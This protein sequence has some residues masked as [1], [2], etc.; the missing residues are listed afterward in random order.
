[1]EFNFH[2]VGV[3]TENM[4]RS[5]ADYKVI[6]GE[7]KI[8]KQHY[9]ASQGVNVC[10]V[11]VGGGV[12]IELIE[13]ADEKTTIANFIQKKIKYYHAGYTVFDFDR[14]IEHLCRNNF[15]HLETFHSEA[16]GGN[17]CAFLYTNDL[18]LI[19]LIEKK[20]G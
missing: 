12:F 9:I 3:I 11:E 19:E 17:R 1:M 15:K 16:F 10:F 14:A 18:H 20:H 7:N 5:L 13:P 8:S 2:H 6:F 4:T